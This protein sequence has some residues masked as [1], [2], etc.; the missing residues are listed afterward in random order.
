MASRA[1][2]SGQAGADGPVPSSSRPPKRSANA[3]RVQT[4]PPCSLPSNPH[5]AQAKDC[6]KPAQPGQMAAPSPRRP[7]RTRS[8][9]QPG[10]I[11]RV[12][13]A[14]SAQARQT[15]PSGQAPALFFQQRSGSSRR[16]TSAR[17]ARR[18]RGAAHA[19][20]SRMRAGRG[21]GFAAPRAG[22]AGRRWRSGDAGVLGGGGHQVGRGAL[23]DVAE[24]GQHLQR[25]PLR[26]AGHQPVDLGGGQV[27]AAVVQ[28]RH[29]L[30]RGVDLVPGH[31]LAQ[32]PGVADLASYVCLTV[33]WVP[34][35]AATVAS[36]CRRR[37]RVRKSED[38][39]V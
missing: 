18:W 19:P 1:S 15:C 8:W 7:G 35:A 28:H 33:A 38:T 39:Q 27:D 24:R 5:R 34:R 14:R 2:A 9:P 16:S 12:R 32:V 23:Q 11:P 22:R 29:Q 36:R 30:G 13:R 3:Q 10:Q 17:T 4:R 37:V 31:H 26:G 25:Q 21:R 6:E 20:S